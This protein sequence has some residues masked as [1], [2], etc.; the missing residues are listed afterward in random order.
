MPI[1]R[2][3]DAVSGVVYGSIRAGAEIA[4]HLLGTRMSDTSATSESV[5]TVVNGLWGDA[6]GSYGDHLE[7]PMAVRDH[8][9]APVVLPTDLGSIFPGATGHLAILIHGLVE[10]ERCWEGSEGEPGLGEALREHP[11]LTSVS[12]RYN[13]GLRISD[14]GAQLARLLEELRADWPVPIETISLVGHS[15]GGLVIRSACEAAEATNLRWIQDVGDVVTLGTPHAGSPLEKAANVA[16]WALALAP[17]TRPLADFLKGRSGGIKDLRFG[18]I[19]E[20]DWRGTDPDALLSNTVGDHPLPS[21]IRHHFVAGVATADPVHPLGRAVGDLVVRANS[22]TGGRDLD[23]TSE[24]V[25]GGVRHLDLPRKSVVVERV[26]AWLA[27]A[28]S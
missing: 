23:P 14:N 27:G 3:H 16:A 26:M 13:S 20:D 28:D 17:D 24:V 8:N 5:Q 12:V 18:A 6:L 4:G 21:G 25:L 22:A 19:M 7:I 2:T 15:M 1:R 11:L 10:T 9:G